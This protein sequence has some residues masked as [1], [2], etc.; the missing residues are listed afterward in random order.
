VSETSQIT[1]P[2]V[3][4]LEQAGCLVM[5]M[6]V[7]K[8]KIGRN[9]IQMHNAGTADILCFTRTGRVLWLECKDPAG[10]TLKPQKAAQGAFKSLVEAFGHEYLIVKS[11][12]QGLEALG[13]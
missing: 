13:E 3:K 5:R 6:P 2:L 4:A 9:Y 10:K 1:G 7:G 8:A 12:A 11:V